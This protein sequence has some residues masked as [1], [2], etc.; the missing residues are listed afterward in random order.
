[1]LNPEEKGKLTR[2]AIQ[3]RHYQV[4]VSDSK[5]KLLEEEREILKADGGAIFRH[6][7]YSEN[8]VSFEV[9]TLKKRKIKIQFLKK[10]KYQLFIDNE[11]KKIFTGRSHELEV[12]EGEHTVLVQLL[13]ERE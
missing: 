10:G 4:E 12:P 11:I 1:M 7:L 6:F 5:T 3:G 2:L 13:E 9:K 8:E